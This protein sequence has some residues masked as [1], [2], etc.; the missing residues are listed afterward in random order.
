[1]AFNKRIN[2]LKLWVIVP[3]VLFF[4]NCDPNDYCI[5]YHQ[6]EIPVNIYAANDTIHIGDTIS[7]DIAFSRSLKEILYPDHIFLPDKLLKSG[8]S[9]YKID[10]NNIKLLLYNTMGINNSFDTLSIIGSFTNSRIINYEITNDSVFGKFR[11][12]AKDTGTF[13]FVLNDGLLNSAASIEELSISFGTST[14]CSE[15]YLP[16]LFKNSNINNN[17]YIIQQRQV[18]FDS[19]LVRY[20]D[21]NIARNISDPNN[22]NSV[23]DDKR[24]LEF[25]TFSVVVKE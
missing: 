13:V 12:I 14:E 17:F 5:L 6:V 8:I 1:M 3:I 9:I 23:N 11:F 20:Y 16:C 2:Q 18:H 7:L 21:G 10:S 4:S 19:T 25:G 15:M 24:N 22:K